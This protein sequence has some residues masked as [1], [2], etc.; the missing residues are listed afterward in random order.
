MLLTQV[1]QAVSPLS[2]M[3]GQSAAEQ[4]WAV[5]S[6]QLRLPSGLSHT[7]NP[8]GQQLCV[9]LSES[10]SSAGVIAPSGS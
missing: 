6:T 5:G 3:A 9:E 1:Q 8:A 7:A 10:I 4:H 2:S